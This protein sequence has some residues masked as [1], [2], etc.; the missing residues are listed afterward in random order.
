MENLIEY[1][2]TLDYL[3]GPSIE[4]CIQYIKGSLYTYVG[5]G[6]VDIGVDGCR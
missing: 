5:L 2:D 1:I 6:A 4:V 3:C